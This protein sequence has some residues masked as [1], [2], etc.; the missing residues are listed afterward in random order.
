MNIFIS[1][2]VT[3]V[4]FWGV[5][6][7]SVAILKTFPTSWLANVIRRHLIDDQGLEP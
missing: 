3:V 6:F 1:V 5:L 7:L 4:L 2:M